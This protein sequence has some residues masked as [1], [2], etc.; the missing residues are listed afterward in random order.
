MQSLISNRQARI[1]RFAAC[2]ATTALAFFATLH[3]QA[4]ATDAPS[5]VTSVTDAVPWTDANVKKDDECAL[6]RRAG[7]LDRVPDEIKR[8]IIKYALCDGSGPSRM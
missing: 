8:A 3:W 5:Q 1:I 4:P 6:V 2:A 7:A